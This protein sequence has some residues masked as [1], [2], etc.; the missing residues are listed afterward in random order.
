MLSAL[1]KNNYWHLLSSCTKRSGF[2][3]TQGPSHM[4]ELPAFTLIFTY[5]RGSQGKHVWL[6]PKHSTF[7]IRLCCSKENRQG[8]GKWATDRWLKEGAFSM[9]DRGRPPGG[10][11]RRLLRAPPEQRHV[12]LKWLHLGSH[13]WSAHNKQESQPS[14]LHGGSSPCFAHCPRLE[15]VRSNAKKKHAKRS[16]CTYGPAHECPVAILYFT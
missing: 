4:C 14:I 8:V 13:F 3:R 5:G 6:R 1:L 15:T 10:L 2:R 11:P 7:L 9:C 16:V 12:Q